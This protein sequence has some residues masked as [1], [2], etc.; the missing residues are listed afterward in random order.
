VDSFRLE[1][2]FTDE[3]PEADDGDTDHDAAADGDEQGLVDSS[4]VAGGSNA[5][6]EADGEEDA[7]GA[8]NEVNDE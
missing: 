1:I 3:Q 4:E 8:E 5:H 7:K 2:I 6:D